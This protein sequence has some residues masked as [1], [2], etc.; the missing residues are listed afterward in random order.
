MPR[1]LAFALLLAACAQGSAP[2]APPALLPIDEI[3]A[4][5]PA[6]DASPADTLAARGDSLRARAARLR[7]ATP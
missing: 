6:A 4:S 5:V 2:G 1:I 7:A 3:L